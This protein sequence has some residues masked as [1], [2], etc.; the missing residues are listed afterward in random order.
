MQFCPYCV[1]CLCSAT[2]VF[3]G[4]MSTMSV[5]I[6]KATPT[7]PLS[8]NG[9]YRSCPSPAVPQLN[10][11]RQAGEPAKMTEELRQRWTLHPSSTT[12]IITPLIRIIILTVFPL[13]INR[14]YPPMPT[15]TMPMCPHFSPWPM[16]G[17]SCCLGETVRPPPKT[18]HQCPHTAK[19]STT[20]LGSHTPQGQW[21][22]TKKIVGFSSATKGT[23]IV[24][25]TYINS[26]QLYL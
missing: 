24:Q 9:H 3:L 4:T 26:T 2:V 13:A 19:E 16:G 10:P 21:I 8:P 14:Q 22:E 6:C 18:D 25:G 11:S 1:W 20:S 17:S 12:I 15:S 23:T 5:R 7:R